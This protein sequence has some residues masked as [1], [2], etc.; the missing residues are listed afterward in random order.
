MQIEEALAKLAIN[1]GRIATALEAIVESQGI[2]AGTRPP[3]P[4]D[5]QKELPLEPAAEE[6]QDAEK[7][8]AKKKG[9]KKKG[10]KKNEIVVGKTDD[11]VPEWDLPG[12]RGKLH[13]LQEAENQA[14]VKSALKKFGASTLGQVDAKKYAQLAEHIDGLLDD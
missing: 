13:E 5:D 8:P 2:V 3:A 12:I 4:H 11:E 10:K 14:A 1:T 7:K 9:K 6:K